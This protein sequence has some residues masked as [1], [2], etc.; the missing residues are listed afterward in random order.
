MLGY[1]RTGGQ[2]TI[3]QD[4]ARDFGLIWYKKKDTRVKKA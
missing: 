2:M 3:E 1:I 4:K